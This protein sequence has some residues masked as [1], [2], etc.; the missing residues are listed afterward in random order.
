MPTVLEINYKISLKIESDTRSPLKIIFF[1]EIINYYLLL[2]LY[3]LVV[4]VFGYNIVPVCL[5]YILLKI[6][7]SLF[8]F[9]FF[10]NKIDIFICYIFFL[11]VFDNAL[12]PE[13]RICHFYYIIFTFTY[14]CLPIRGCKNIEIFQYKYLN[15]S[16]GSLFY[17]YFSIMVYKLLIR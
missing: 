8:T 7:F 4:N 5:L 10:V 3:C 2:L 11:F 16:S 12:Y 1:Y 17:S 6:Y 14:L 15:S 13:F 9:F